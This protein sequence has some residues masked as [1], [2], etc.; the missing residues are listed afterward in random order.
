MLE[1]L[2]KLLIAALAAFGLF[3]NLVV[4]ERLASL[5]ATTG[6]EDEA[7]IQMLSEMGSLAIGSSISGF[8]SFGLLGAVVASFICEKLNVRPLRTLAAIGA[9]VV[10][11]GY[12]L[13]EV[14]NRVVADIGMKLVSEYP[15]QAQ[16]AL[17]T[18]Y[19][20]R[21]TWRDHNYRNNLIP[22][23][24]DDNLMSVEANLF[25]VNMFY[26]VQDPRKLIG[27][28]AENRDLLVTYF[29]D[30]KEFMDIRKTGHSIETT[31]SSS[32]LEKEYRSA[33][34]D[35][36]RIRNAAVLPLILAMASVSFILSC[37]ILVAEVAGLL[38]GGRSNWL[39]VRVLGITAV[40][41]ILLVTPLFID[42]HYHSSPAFQKLPCTDSLC[43]VGRPL[44]DWMFRFEVAFI[45]LVDVVMD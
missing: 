34:Y 28:K 37:M 2:P 43:S 36:Q 14:Q 42:T 4:I 5:S 1:R 23:Y 44:M 31:R 29:S 18:Y 8:V 26:L 13:G 40:G 45:S 30:Y 3:A 38:G 9:S 20:Q 11:C 39:K 10:V 35:L 6:V 17:D 21:L 15:G 41:A 22:E 12:L 25:R 24:R 27:P 7:W 19:V 32:G 33:D 16:R